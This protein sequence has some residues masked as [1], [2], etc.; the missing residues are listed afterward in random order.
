MSE[1]TLDLITG[2]SNF[3]GVAIE[4]ALS[5]VDIAY[6][7]EDRVRNYFRDSKLRIV[8]EE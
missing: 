2:R 6:C 8:L 7:L 3:I 1:K 5:G 4:L